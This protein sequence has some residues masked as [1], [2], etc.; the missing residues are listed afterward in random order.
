MGYAS[1]G[2]GG[3][4]SEILFR[5]RLEAD[6][7]ETVYDSDRRRKKLLYDAANEI[8]MLRERNSVLKNALEK[9]EFECREGSHSID[10]LWTIAL[11]AI[12]KGDKT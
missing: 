1:Q 2:A 9:I 5:L 8:E 3:C 10:P 12:A 4:M 11:E 7:H 6:E